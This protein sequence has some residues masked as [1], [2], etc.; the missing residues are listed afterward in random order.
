MPATPLERGM[1]FADL[2][3]KYLPTPNSICQ[4]DEN[5]VYVAAYWV[6]EV[7]LLVCTS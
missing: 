1:R 6:F 7:L 3:K 5:L 4:V 2:S